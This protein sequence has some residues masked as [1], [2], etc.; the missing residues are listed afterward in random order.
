M[1]FLLIEEL[2]QLEAVSAEYFSPQVTAILAELA[3]K[4]GT[5]KDFEY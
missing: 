5:D 1:I 3:A 4:D 2:S